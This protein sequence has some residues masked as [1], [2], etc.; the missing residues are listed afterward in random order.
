M[1]LEFHYKTFLKM[2]NLVQNHR[3]QAFPSIT[4]DDALLQFKTGIEN[5]IVTGGGRAKISLIRSQNGIKLI[6]NAIK[7]ELVNLGIHPSLINPSKKQLKR[8]INPTAYSK[9]YKL[10]DKE[11]KL[12]GYIK[13]K[14][15]DISIIPSNIPIHPTTLSYPTNLNGY[16]DLYGDLLTESIL[17]INVRSQ[18]SSTNKN[19]DTMYERTFAEPLNLHLRCPKMVLGE[20]YIFMLNEYNSNEVKQKRVVFDKMPPKTIEKY[21]KSFQAVNSRPN[22][23]TDDYKYERCCL[24]LVDFNRSIPKIYGDTQTL[25][26]DGFLPATTTVNMSNLSYTEF[27]QDLLDI[28]TSRFPA[29]TFT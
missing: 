20:L 8:A 16:Y 19:Y 6:H 18:L 21:I 17:T 10:Y 9:P 27:E 29:N 26:Q 11:R 1:Q 22:T 2:T 24:L 15:Q 23:T 3:G 13:T 12:A 4:M 5:A 28:Y 14:D 25:I 7:T